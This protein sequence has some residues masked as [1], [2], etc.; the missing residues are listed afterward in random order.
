[1]IFYNLDSVERL[2]TRILHAYPTPQF[3][4][5]VIA[6]MEICRGVN[7]AWVLVSSLGIIEAWLTSS[8]DLLFVYRYCFYLVS[9][10]VSVTSLQ[11][12]QT[13]SWIGICSV[14][15]FSVAILL[16]VLEIYVGYKCS[17]DDTV[18]YVMR[19]SCDV[20]KTPPMGTDA[21]YFGE[22]LTEELVVLMSSLGS[23]VIMWIVHVKSKGQQPL[24]RVQFPHSHQHLLSCMSDEFISA[25]EGVSDHASPKTVHTNL[26]CI[27][28][29]FIY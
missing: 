8:Q 5:M 14:I 28:C 9:S 4:V 17:S 10:L 22:Y 20:V 18:E 16:H 3:L 11:F 19:I 23:L 6:A 15:G 13:N 29:M 27:L 12:R 26:F 24:L 1:M 21:S 2:N 25:D 7:L